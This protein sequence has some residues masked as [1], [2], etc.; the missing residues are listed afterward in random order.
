[1]QSKDRELA[2]AQQQLRH[3]VNINDIAIVTI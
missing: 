3:E 1:M 2:E